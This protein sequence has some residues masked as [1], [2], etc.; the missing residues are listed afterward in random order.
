MI[1]WILILASFT[2][3][4]EITQIEHIDGFMSSK[5]CTAAGELWFSEMITNQNGLQYRA[6]YTCVSTK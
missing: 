3:D 6:K 5:A 1:A 4:Y 2:T